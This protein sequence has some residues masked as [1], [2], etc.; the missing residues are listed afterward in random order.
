MCV[1]YVCGCVWSGQALPAEVVR[2]QAP[3]PVGVLEGVEGVLEGLVPEEAGLPSRQ[4]RLV[5]EASVF[6]S[7]GGE[8]LWKQGEREEEIYN[9]M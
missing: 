1:W 6:G 7:V 8:A 3:L 9:Q 4:A 2:A 5:L